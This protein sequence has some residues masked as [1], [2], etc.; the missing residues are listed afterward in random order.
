M[1]L[2]P[3]W[4]AAVVIY[5]ILA[6][7]FLVIFV[8][9]RRIYRTFQWLHFFYSLFNIPKVNSA[10][11]LSTQPDESMKKGISP[12][13][14]PPPPPRKGSLRGQKCSP[15]VKMKKIGW[16]K[17]PLDKQD[18]NSVWRKMKDEKISKQIMSRC[19]YLFEDLGSQKTTQRS[20]S[21]SKIQLLE[22][23]RSNQIQIVLKVLPFTFDEICSSLINLDISKWTLSQLLSLQSILP[24]KK[25]KEL[26]S[27]YKGNIE[28]LELSDQ[29]F[30][31]ILKTE[32]MMMKMFNVSIDDLINSLISRASFQDEFLMLSDHVELIINALDSI[33]NS[34]DDLTKF[35]EIFLAVG[36]CMDG[37]SNRGGCDAVKL[38]SLLK[39]KNT[40][41]SRDTKMTAFHFVA[42]IIQ[43]SNDT[44][45]I[46][47]P[48][49]LEC[50]HRACK[51]DVTDVTQKLTEL[52]ESVQIVKDF[53]EKDRSG[54]MMELLGEF[55]AAASIKLTNL[56]E[57][58]LESNE[59][60][61][62]LM[63][64][65]GCDSDTSFLQIWS[66]ILIEF[67]TSLGDL[68]KW[69]QEEEV[70]ECKRSC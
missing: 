68:N 36:H 33:K 12:P 60:T 34:Q 66:D 47:L 38:E 52:K 21:K 3:D 44:K 8:I 11:Q 54:K 6:P 43:K 14:P 2:V 32:E 28:S 59:K 63:K 10:G 64:I 70:R 19:E 37:P 9:L 30:S 1:V 7:I 39:F 49:K 22:L 55:D 67:Q 48:Q 69:E 27:S 58:L 16:V 42:E 50:V 41:S 62:N 45:F 23:Q 40:K 26:I 29:Y 61:Q 5:T 13:P 20:S 25:E 31:K 15:S 17:L 24:T 56:S 51:V 4:L 53:I 35:L 57:N 46:Q 18:T 65:Y